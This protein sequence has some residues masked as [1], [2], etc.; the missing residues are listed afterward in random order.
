MN[1]LA[2]KIEFLKRIGESFMISVFFS[3][4]PGLI[5]GW[6]ESESEWVL[7]TLMVVSAIASGSLCY[8]V[9]RWWLMK[10]YY[11]DAKP[12]GK[13]MF[14]L[15]GVVGM[16]PPCLV[17]SHEPVDYKAEIL[18]ATYD[19][20]LSR[21]VYDRYV[22][23]PKQVFSI[24][25]CGK[26]ISFKTAKGYYV[27]NL[28][29]DTLAL[30]KEFYSSKD[31]F[32]DPELLTIVP[33]GCYAQTEH[34]DDYGLQRYGPRPFVISSKPERVAITKKRTFNGKGTH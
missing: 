28:S 3:L 14:L 8:A 13:R 24:D 21:V 19:Q 18:V 10:E 32:R 12:W 20:D 11:N 27:A 1:E 7:Y 22:V 29:D 23:K 31:Q 26:S 16:L 9:A 17:L 34:V 33:P 4:I 30:Y 15:L 5:K 6:L 25:S 2:E